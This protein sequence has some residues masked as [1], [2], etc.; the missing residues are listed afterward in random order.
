MSKVFCPKI[1]RFEL[2]C[3]IVR[4]DT[5]Q[6]GPKKLLFRF[7]SDVSDMLYHQSRGGMPS[8]SIDSNRNGNSFSLGNSSPFGFMGQPE[9]KSE[10]RSKPED[11]KNWKDGLQRLLPN[12]NIR[13]ADNIQNNV[14]QN[15]HMNNGFGNSRSQNIQQPDVF[16]RLFPNPPPSNPIRGQLCAF[17]Y[18]IG[19]LN[20][21]GTFV[22]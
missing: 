16:S 1:V 5:S 9:S 14:N 2:N 22:F 6:K 20:L 18:I 7:N 15:Q 13:F 4:N 19:I 17:L 3:P 11:M 12:V 21:T 10:A 8:S